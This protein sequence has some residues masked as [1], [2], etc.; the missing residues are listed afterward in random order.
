[1]LRA[2]VAALNANANAASDSILCLFDDQQ[3]QLIFQLDAE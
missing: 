3:T 2:A 1:M